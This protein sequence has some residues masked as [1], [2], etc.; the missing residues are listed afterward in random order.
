[1]GQVKR[2]QGDLAGAAQAFRQYNAIM[3]ALTQRDPDNAGWQRDLYMSH[4]NFGD[5]REQQNDWNAAAEQYAQ[6]LAIAEK[7]QQADK[8]KAADKGDVARLRRDLQRVWAK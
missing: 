6:A 1:V 5:V 7:L 4:W 8:L 3:L 2:A